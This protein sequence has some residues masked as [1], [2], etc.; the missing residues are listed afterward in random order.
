VALSCK[1]VGEDQGLTNLCRINLSVRDW[2]RGIYAA[3]AD[4][5]WT[6]QIHWWRPDTDEFT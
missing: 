2:D 1:F 3:R 6:A 4:V 5:V